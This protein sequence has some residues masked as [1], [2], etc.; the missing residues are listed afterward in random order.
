[1]TLL[2]S[3]HAAAA[4]LGALRSSARA[5]RTAAVLA[6]AAHAP[7]LFRLALSTL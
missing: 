6:L 2:W 7:S 5:G 4:S 3:R 1:M